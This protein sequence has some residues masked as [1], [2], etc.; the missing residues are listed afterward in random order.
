MN[1]NDLQDEVERRGLSDSVRFPGEVENAEMPR[2][3]SV[4]DLVVMTSE[5]EGWPL[6]VLEAHAAGRPVV[7][8]DIP[9]TQEL[10]ALGRPVS[11]FPVGDSG[12]LAGRILDLLAN[13]ERRRALGRAGREAALKDDPDEWARAHSNVIEQVAVRASR[14]A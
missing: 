12:A 6:T 14:P 11:A 10:N 4:A 8:S 7:A 13:R 3:L 2:W 9:A 1:G 5:R